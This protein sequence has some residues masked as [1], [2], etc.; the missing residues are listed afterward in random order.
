[1]EN[2]YETL[3]PNRE[4]GLGDVTLRSSLF[5]RSAGIRYTGMFRSKSAGLGSLENELYVG[6]SDE[7]SDERIGDAGGVEA[8][9]G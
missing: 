2:S 6:E 5:P 4:T 3:H 9:T 8:P 7:G 1:M